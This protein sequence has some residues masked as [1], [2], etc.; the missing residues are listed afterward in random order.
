MI[1]GGERFSS[2]VRYRV[3]RRTLGVRALI[4]IAVA[5]V[6][7]LIEQSADVYLSAHGLS[8]ADIILDDVVG[9]FLLGATAFLWVTSV[10]EHHRRLRAEERHELTAEMN[11]HVR[12][13]LTVIKY[14]AHTPDRDER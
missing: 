13:A 2:M 10:D 3:S 4:A 5:V 9:A 12:N 11:H 7:A 1:L 8:H 14:A 6:F